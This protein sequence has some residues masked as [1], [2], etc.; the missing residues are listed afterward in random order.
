MRDKLKAELVNALE[1]GGDEAA[2]EIVSFMNERQGRKFAPVGAVKWVNI[3]DVVGN[4]YNPNTVPKNEMNL[5]AISIQHDGYCVEANTPVL[6]ADLTWVPA[7]DLIVGD[8]VVAFDEHA[9]VRKD[10]SATPRKLRTAT[11]LGN[12]VEPSDLL[13]IKTDKGEIR[14]TPDHPFLAQRCYGKG[15]HMATWIMAKDLKTGDAIIHLMDPWEVDKSWKAGWLSGFLDGEGTLS[16]NQHKDHAQAVRLAGYQKPGMIADRMIHEMSK[17]VKTQVF[18]V[19]RKD[20]DK[21]DDMVMVRVDRLYDIMKLVGSVR[22]DRLLEVAGRFWEGRSLTKSHRSKTKAIVI[23]ISKAGIGDIARLS[24]STKTYIANGFAVH[25]TQPVVTI[26]D[27]DKKKYVVVDGFHRYLTMKMNKEI[28]E[29]YHGKLPVVILDKSP[30]ERMASTVRHNRARGK[31]SMTGMGILIGNMKKEGATDAEI[32]NELGLEPD[33]YIRLQ[34][35]TGVALLYK[36]RSYSRA[37]ESTSV[38]KKI[39]EEKEEY[40]KKHRKNSK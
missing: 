1:V 37:W 22:P 30:K 20:H 9:E 13:L 5:L 29:L 4:D 12:K 26:W 17:R 10:K 11:V 33:E 6:K 24:T 39:K 21:W 16:G 7:G 27:E 38:I 32:C 14:V 40:V 36:D 35:T 8:E 23:N 2:Y 3:D 28:N 31:H 15:Y 18:T 25:N 19:D 34:H